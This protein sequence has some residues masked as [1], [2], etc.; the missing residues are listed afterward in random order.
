MMWNVG[1]VRRAAL[2]GELST[3][4]MCVVAIARYARVLVTHQIHDLLADKFRPAAILSGPGMKAITSHFKR[5]CCP[6]KRYVTRGDVL[7]DPVLQRAI[8]T[9]RILA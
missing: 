5:L 8:Q 4:P 3:I 2:V 1:R 7:A 9:C 6:I